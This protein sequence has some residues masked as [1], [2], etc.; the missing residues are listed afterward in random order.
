MKRQAK[1]ELSPKAPVKA[2]APSP[3]SPTKILGQ[4]GE[5][6][7][8]DFLRTRGYSIEAR[9]FRTKLG[10]IDIV[11]TCQGQF[12]FIEVKTRRTATYGTPAQAVD[13]R[14]QQ[15]IISVAECYLRQKKLSDVP[16]RFDVIE[17]YASGQGSWHIEHIED[18][19]E[20]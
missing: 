3:P 15:K 9:N 16:C 17:V 2:A 4:Q 11:A 14:K 6:A 20:A 10:E 7:A 5:T 19:F 18:A 1:I 8:A 12:V 13:Y